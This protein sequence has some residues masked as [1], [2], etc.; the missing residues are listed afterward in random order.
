MAIC[1]VACIVPDVAL[2]IIQKLVKT[3]VGILPFA[4]DLDP[5]LTGLQGLNLWH[6]SRLAEEG[7]ENAQNLAESDI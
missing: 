5:P 2:E 6:Q 7:I 1:F 3:A 4:K